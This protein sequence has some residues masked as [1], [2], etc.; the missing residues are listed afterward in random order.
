MLKWLIKFGLEVAPPVAATVIGAFLVHQ[1]WPTQH[2]EVPPPA[3]PPAVQSSADSATASPP[4]TVG[5]NSD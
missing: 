5:A 3:T 2:P 4:A 1:L